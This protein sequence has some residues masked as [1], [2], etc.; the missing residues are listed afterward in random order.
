MNKLILTTGAAVLLAAGLFAGPASAQA[1][2]QA[3]AAVQSEHATTTDVS[4]RRRH[5]RHR[6]GY[7]RHY[8]RPYRYGYY[9]PYYAYAGAPY[10]YG[11]PRYYYRP[12]PFP[13]GPF[14]P[15]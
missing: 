8:Y 12:S 6:H 5:W 7:Y 13:F 3:N 4:A 11:P 15:F 9:R 14:F 1:R 2:T 10:Y